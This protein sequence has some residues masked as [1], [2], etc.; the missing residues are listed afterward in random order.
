M[1]SNHEPDSVF[2]SGLER[3]LAS[4]L[5]RQRRFGPVERTWGLKRVVK[6]SVLILLCL[7]T[8]VAAAKTVEHFESARRKALLQAR[9]ETAMEVIQARMA[10]AREIVR[11]MEERVEAGIVHPRELA[12]AVHQ[13]DLLKYELERARLD[14]EEVDLSSQAPSD[15]LFASLPGGRDFVTERLRVESRVV[16]AKKKRLEAWTARMRKLVEAG[17]ANASETLQLDM[18]AGKISEALEDVER[19]LRL[20]EAFL[21]GELTARQAGLR[22]MLQRAGT[23]LQTA[24]RVLEEAEAQFK[25]ASEANARGLV[26]SIEVKQAEHQLVSARAEQRLARM[27]LELLEEALN[28]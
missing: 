11:M 12:E 27:E 18:Q 23:R 13:S 19:R 17:L 15:E 3:Q 4:E 20:R 26:S 8:G 25:E 22:Q 2:I 16:S 28:E 24:E 5:R 6:S 9:V 1:K 10:V 21:S 14:M 7:A